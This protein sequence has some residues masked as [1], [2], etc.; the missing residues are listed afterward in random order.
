MSP[1]AARVKGSDFL[2]KILGLLLLLPLALI[3]STA[4]TGA[5]NYL[6]LF[7]VAGLIFLSVLT[8]FRVGLSLIAFCS[9][10]LSFSIWYLHLPREL[11]SL[12]YFLIIL[13]LFREFFFTANLQPVRTP[14]NY[15]L[16]LVVA[17]GLLSI[18]NGESAM[19]ASF[20]A[21]LRH[22]GYPLLF[23]LILTA[24]P[25]EKLMRKL[26]WVIL[27]VGLLQI[28]ASAWQFFY[29]WIINPKDAG[30][31]ADHSS[32]LLGYSCGGHTA[33]MMAMIFCLMMAFALV[34]GF[35]LKRLLAAASTIVPVFLASARAGVL[36]FAIAGFFMMVFAPLQKHIGL[37]QRVF[38]GGLMVALIATMVLLGV[39]G[40]SFKFVF[41]WDYMYEYSM[42]TSDSGLGRLQAFGF[43]TS[44]LSDPVSRMI[45]LGPGTLTPTQLMK[46]PRALINQ[47]ADLYRN[48]TGY[49]VTTIE[50]G[51][52]G[53]ALFLL[54]YFRIYRAVRRFLKQIDDPFWEAISLGFCGLTIVYIVSI[55]YV[56]SWIYYPLPFTFWA[57]AA[58]IYR[59]GII[60]GIF[61]G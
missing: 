49:T 50:L 44:K 47:D 34:K 23:I 19:L 25:D 43:V 28:P 26:V 4:A 33:I 10:F 15:L 60:K 48:V 30:Y 56:D 27:L 36:F 24:Q 22:I 45:G 17:L 41:D 39:G 57:L 2:K 61:E 5:N 51:F 32:G 29:Y 53:L 16:M 3:L 31:R 6:L 1:V 9:Y 58:A 46:N 18:A 52:L 35:T 7:I 40:E 54:I 11:I 37:A 12:T 42:K 20:K 59:V 38:L 13:V 14:I 21:L 55:V 8:D